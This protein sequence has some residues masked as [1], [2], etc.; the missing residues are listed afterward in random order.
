MHRTKEN[1]EQNKCAH[2][3]RNL[4]IFV[5]AFCFFFCFFLFFAF[6]V[7]VVDGRRN[8]LY[9]FIYYYYF[10]VRPATF[11]RSMCS[12]LLSM[13]RKSCTIPTQN[14]HIK[15]EETYCSSAQNSIPTFQQLEFRSCISLYRY[16]NRFSK[17]VKVSLT[18]CSEV[19]EMRSWCRI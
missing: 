12:A 15:S 7:T 10:F 19:R 17:M 18:S 2:Y 16:H 4:Y 8:N 5:F 9:L 13:H 3:A 11:S 6:C 14:T 1:I